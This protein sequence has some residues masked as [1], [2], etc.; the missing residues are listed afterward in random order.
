M[1]Q[2]IIN[3]MGSNTIDSC[4][5]FINNFPA[6][7]VTKDDLTKRKRVKNVVPSYERCMAKR[8]SGERCTRRCKEQAQFC[9]TH[10]KGTPHGLVDQNESTNVQLKKV[11][12]KY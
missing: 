7:Q 8:A 9:G 3:H 11:L 12:A 2:E 1:K 4:I 6:L 5:S 10:T